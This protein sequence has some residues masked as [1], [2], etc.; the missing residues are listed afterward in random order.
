ML[1]GIKKIINDY[2]IKLMFNEQNMVSH[3]VVLAERRISW[4][5]AGVNDINIDVQL[6]PP[7]DELANPILVTNTLRNNSFLNENIAFLHNNPINKEFNSANFSFK[8]EPLRFGIWQKHNWQNLE[9][10]KLMNTLLSYD[11]TGNSR[12]ALGSI[13]INYEHRLSCSNVETSQLFNR[14]LNQNTVNV[15][16]RALNS[17]NFKFSYLINDNCKVNIDFFLKNDSWHISFNADNRINENNT[18]EQVLAEDFYHSHYLPIAIHLVS[19]V[20]N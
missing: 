14:L 7:F 19:S 3:S 8:L 1:S 6:P 15:G 13:G 16:N 2:K 4:L 10:A 18:V 11:V 5:S 12:R 17:G 20:V 9:C